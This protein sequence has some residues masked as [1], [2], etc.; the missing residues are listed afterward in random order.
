[1][2]LSNLKIG[3]LRKLFIFIGF[4]SVVSI[5]SVAP[6][7]FR[8]DGAAQ[9]WAAK[10]SIEQLEILTHIIPFCLTI[11]EDYTLG[12]EHLPSWISEVVTDAH[13]VGTEVIVGVG[14]WGLS[15]GFD[16]AVLPDNRGQFVSNLKEFY[17]STGIDGFNLDWEYPTQSQY[18]D[19]IATIVMLR[20][21]IPSAE[22][23]FAAAAY[24]DPAVFPDEFYD[25]I[26]VVE[27]MTYDFQVRGRGHADIEV[28]R[29]H[30]ETWGTY[31]DDLEARGVTFSRKS[32][33]SGIPFYGRIIGLPNIGA[34]Y[35]EIIAAGGS[36]YSDRWQEIRGTFGYTGRVTVNDITTHAIDEGFGGVMI[37]AID[38]DIP[39]SDERSLL[40]CIDESINGMSVNSTNELVSTVNTGITVKSLNASEINLSVPQSGMYSISLLSLNGRLISQFSSNIE[41]GDMQSIPFRNNIASGS[42]LMKVSG[43]N[44]EVNSTEKIVVQ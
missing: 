43:I 42:Y 35:K 5:A 11:N 17:T 14:G 15:D 44:V 10:P 27:L 3:R 19:Y 28:T 20:D 16:A 24:R 32:I 6:D 18:P 29:P 33:M 38:Q 7:D 41:A 22:I 4:L 39:V 37:W 36:S 26:D 25:A 21:S 1:M 40:R 34:T 2:L 23:G 30:L 31:A 13:S 12:K 9:G 8:V